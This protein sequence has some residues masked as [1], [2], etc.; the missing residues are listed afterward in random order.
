MIL[1]TFRRKIFII[2]VI[3]VHESRGNDNGLHFMG[4]FGVFVL[5]IIFYQINRRHNICI[6]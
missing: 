6:L 1:V 3:I 4:K 5:Y 2:L